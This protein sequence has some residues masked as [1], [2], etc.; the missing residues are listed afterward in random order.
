MGWSCAAIAADTLNRLSAKC[1]ESSGSSNVWESGGVRFFFEPSRVE[2]GDG[3]IT[4]SIWRMLPDN[5]AR[6]VGSF[7]IEADGRLSRSAGG[8]SKLLV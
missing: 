4:G 3:A 6:R 5:M 7:R 8:L 2:H 1:R